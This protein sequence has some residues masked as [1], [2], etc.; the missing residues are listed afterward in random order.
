MG[1]EALVRHDEV[2]SIGALSALQEMRKP[3][4]CFS[5]PHFGGNVRP[6]RRIHEMISMRKI[7]MDIVHDVFR[8]LKI[9]AR[10]HF[11][12]GQGSRR[13]R[14]SVRGLCDAHHRSNG[15]LAATPEG[16]RAE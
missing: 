2:K 5:C 13:R 15:I 7:H 1:Q 12:R 6:R 14:L 11:G 16:M 9:V 8:A 3:E 10:D 4:W